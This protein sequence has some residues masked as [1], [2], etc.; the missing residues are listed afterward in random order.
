M[1]LSHIAGNRVIFTERVSQTKPERDKEFSTGWCLGGGPD[2]LY[3]CYDADLKRL[4]GIDFRNRFR[5]F[6]QMGGKTIYWVRNP[7]YPFVFRDMYLQCFGKLVT[8]TEG[9]KFLLH[10]EGTSRPFVAYDALAL[11]Q[12]GCLDKDI[13]TTKANEF[14]RLAEMYEKAYN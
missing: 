9:T 11:V 5:F 10:T 6:D 2:E 14:F 8:P 1:D 3:D 4:S 13:S 12:S 7:Y